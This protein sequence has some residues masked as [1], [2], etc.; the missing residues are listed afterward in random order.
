MTTVRGIYLKKLNYYTVNLRAIKCKNKAILLCKGN[1]E[2]EKRKCPMVQL[3][4][5][6]G[7]GVIAMVFVINGNPS[8]VITARTRKV[9][10]TMSNRSTGRLEKE[11]IGKAPRKKEYLTKQQK[12]KRKGEN[13]QRKLK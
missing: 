4:K 10:L 6:T 13:H 9:K 3:G 12:K 2:E 5:K 11:L 7:R 8:E 1:N